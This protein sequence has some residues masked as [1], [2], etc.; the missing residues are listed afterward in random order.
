MKIDV[1]F[2]PKDTLAMNLADTTCIVLD[3]FRATTCIVTA[4][5]NGCKTITPV[6]SIDEA[7]VLAGQIK[8]AL[9]AGERQSIKI[10]G[11]DLGNSPFEFC[12]S[13]V[14]EQ[15][16][17][18]T[19]TNGTVAI[20]STDGA[21][22]TLIGSF[23]NAGAVCR[24]ARQYGKDVL[25]ICAGTDGLFSLEDTLCAGLLVR[26]LTAEGEAAVSDSA[27]GALLMYDHYKD[28]LVETA[29]QSRN[30]KRLY[31]IGRTEDIKYCLR[32][33]VFNTVPQYK[34]GKILLG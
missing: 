27:R 12:Q 22:R 1:A 24:Q 23:I 15:S 7:R 17:I 30:G 19:T 6:L 26:L 9:L 2:L 28:V 18:M 33:D 4:F 31:D 20:R 3:I 32:T 13:R 11:C 29:A 14:Q 25:I 8:P 10:E 16:I 21:F 5:A 34:E